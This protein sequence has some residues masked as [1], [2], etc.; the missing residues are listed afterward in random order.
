[1]TD[2]FRSGGPLDVR[3]TSAD[4]Y[5]LSVTLP[6]EPD[7]RISRACVSKECSPGAF[8]NK[9][10][11]GI[12]QNH[13]KAFC[14]YCRS[15]GE[16]GNFATADQIRY[17]TDLVLREAGQGVDRMVKETLGLDSLGK[18]KFGG[19][20]IS[21]EMSYKPGAPKYVR[22]PAADQI[23]R[24]LVCPHCGLDHSVFGLARWC[25]D[26]G[27][28]IFLTH[29]E[30]E[31][32]V[33]RKMVADIER[34]QEILGNRVALKDLENCLE[35]IV[36]IFEAVMRQIARQRL[37]QISETVEGIEAKMRQFGNAFQS[38][39]RTKEAFEGA[40]GVDPFCQ[41]SDDEKNRL[42]ATFEKRHPIV[43]NLGIVDWK[44]LSRVQS[45]E[46]EGREVIVNELE[47]LDAI[48][49]SIGIFGFLCRGQDTSAERAA[50][51]S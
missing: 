32:E 45:A 17:A 51:V 8:K 13:L 44:Y 41:C 26:C 34:R 15:E 49:V 7:G 46:T 9:P 22:R 39:K 42:E 31:F 37:Q 50:S 29:V 2:L 20:F 38:V 47:L 12:T 30:A 23:R 27:R 48:Q 35:D 14:P 4:H 24:D 18:R 3:K 33:T 5:S 28:D 11:T 36:S 21:M 16:P 1:M 25:P 43:H 40:F 19:G 6:P 10:G